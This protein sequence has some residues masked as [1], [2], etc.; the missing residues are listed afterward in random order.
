M[1]HRKTSTNVN[2]AAFVATSTPI[3][4][5]LQYELNLCWFNVSC[6]AMELCSCSGGEHRCKGDAHMSKNEMIV[7]MV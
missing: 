2:S 6:T 3:I 7:A 5:L 1:Q 4:S